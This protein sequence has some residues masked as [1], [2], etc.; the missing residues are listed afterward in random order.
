MDRHLRLIAAL[1]LKDGKLFLADGRAVLLCFAVPILLASAFGLIFDRPGQRI[2][3]Y[4]LPIVLVVEDDDP[5]TRQ[6]VQDMRD[7]EQFNVKQ[8]ARATAQAEVTRRSCGVAIVLPS[9]F[10]ANLAQQMQSGEKPSVE[11]LHHPLSIMECQWAEGVLTEIV[12]RRAA[13]QSFGA[14]GMTPQAFDRPFNVRK[15]AIPAESSHPFNSYSHSFSGMTLQYL[16]FW[17]MECGLLLLRERQRGI[18]G[19]I[20]SA[21]VPLTT[22]LLAKAFAT[23][24]IALAQIGVTFAFGFFVFDVAITGSIS[25]FL[26]LSL[27]V[28]A[29]TAALG[30]FVA[31]L[32]RTESSARNIFI[33]VILA[34]S[35]LGGLWLPAFLLPRW[36]QECS[37]ALPTSWAMRGLDGVTW[38]GQGLAAMYPCLIA[39]TCFA[40]LLLVVAIFQ[41]HW[42]ESRCRRGVIT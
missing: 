23:M 30:L 31:A 5:F 27:A 7:S 8:V 17:G 1:V 10:G 19:R 18:W 26:I 16:L 2:S 35:M 12:Y 4:K 9:G 15:H 38:Q 33:V 28:S 11:L 25:G 29:L 21:P 39:V 3:S 42:S 37:V 6:I 32:G 40:T 14:L 41:F 36:V 24:L 13:A 34:V 22:A 20:R